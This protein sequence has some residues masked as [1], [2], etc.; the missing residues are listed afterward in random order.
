[1][2]NTNNPTNQN[3]EKANKMM[4]EPFKFRINVSLE[5]YPSK[6]DAEMAMHSGKA[7]KAKGYKGKMTFFERS[8][9]IDEFVQ[10]ITSGHTMANIFRF[11]EGELPYKFKTKSGIKMTKYASPYYVDK[12]LQGGL[13][14]QFK[15]NE[16]YYGQQAIFVDIDETRYRSMEDFIGKLKSKPTVGYYTFSD[17][18]IFRRFR[19]VYVL[20]KVYDEYMVEGMYRWIAAW[21][22]SDT[23]EKI[24]DNCGDRKAQAMHGTN[25]LDGLYKNEKAIYTFD[26][27]GR[28]IPPTENKDAILKNN[29][30]PDVTTI[31]ADDNNNNNNITTA[32]KESEGTTNA[33]AEVAAITTRAELQPD[34]KTNSTSTVENS[35]VNNSKNTAQEAPKSSISAPID[36]IDDNLVRDL[37]RCTYEQILRKYFCKYTY[38]YRTHYE[39]GWDEYYKVVED[40]NNFMELYYNYYP[41]KDH[42]HRRWKLFTRMCLRRLMWPGVSINNILF[43]AYIDRERFVDNTDEVVS[44]DRLLYY[45]KRAFSMNEEQIRQKFALDIQ[46]AK[47]KRPKFIIVEYTYLNKR[48]LIPKIRK[49]ITDEKIGLMYSLNMSV[50][51]NVYIMNSLGFKVSRARLYQWTKENGIDTKIKSTLKVSA[52]L[53]DNTSETDENTKNNNTNGVANTVTTTNNNANTNSN[54]VETTSKKYSQTKKKNFSSSLPKPKTQK[55]L[56]RQEENRK[57]ISKYDSRL[58]TQ[59]NSVILDISYAKAY[60]IKQMILHQS[61]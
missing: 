48:K 6:T 59:E 61:V 19:L 28:S 45:A 3:M 44:I 21:I 14:I 39:W 60:R 43:N 42:E 25:H 5:G 35:I 9:T 33:Q 34:C 26:D 57:L 17:R 15:A 41:I 29:P 4:Q 32:N 54:G 53:N 50:A 38:F 37:R 52:T 2:E 1:M 40:D 11:P 7:A 22:E 30:T 8:I 16:Y 13:K 36:T 58:T 47:A 51:D 55:Q 27:F 31:K 49:M 56:Q 20:D 12:S 10:L 18:P 24:K 23:Q 46:I